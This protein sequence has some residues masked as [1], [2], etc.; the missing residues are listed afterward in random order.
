LVEVS[1][2]LDEHATIN[3]KEHNVKKKSGTIS[4]CMVD[5]HTVW[6]RFVGTVELNSR[7]MPFGVGLAGRTNELKQKTLYSNCW[8]VKSVRIQQLELYRMHTEIMN[9]G[10]YEYGKM[11]EKGNQIV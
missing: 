8:K 9:T 7:N 1:V 2:N 3:G 10:K 4:R 5:I 11:Y 6:K